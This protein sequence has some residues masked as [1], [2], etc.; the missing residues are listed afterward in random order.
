MILVPCKAGLQH[1]GDNKQCHLCHSK[2]IENSQRSLA[3]SCA[4]MMSCY[5]S[6]QPGSSLHKI[7]LRHGSESPH[8][9]KP[10]EMAHSSLHIAQG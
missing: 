7:G 2:S 1:K 3:C 4:W 9:L 6:F 8:A 5:V 10:R